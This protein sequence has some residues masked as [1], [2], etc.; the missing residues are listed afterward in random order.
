[1][2]VAFWCGLGDLVS[3]GGVFPALLVGVGDADPDGVELADG[4]VVGEGMPVGETVPDGLGVTGHVPPPPGVPFAPVPVPPF[5][6]PGAMPPAAGEPAVPPDPCW[7]APPVWWAA[8]VAGTAHWVNGAC[9][10]PVIA[11]TTATRQQASTPPVPMPANRS[12][13]CRRPDGSANTGPYSTAGV[14]RAAGPQIC[15]LAERVRTPLDRHRLPRD[16]STVA[17]PG[18]PHRSC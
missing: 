17:V 11:T 1:M 2:T 15:G 4:P 6:P 3:P 8:G 13:R 12:R 14:Y 18:R 10:P 7:P 9:G 16:A 5:P